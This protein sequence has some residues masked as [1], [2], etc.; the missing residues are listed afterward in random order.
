MQQVIYAWNY[1][2]WGGAQIHILSL[3]KEVRKEFRIIVLLPRGSDPQFTNFLENQDVEYRFFDGH[4]D[5]SAANTI[6]KRIH[7]RWSKVKSEFAML[8]LIGEFDL[9]NSIVHVELVPHQSL[10]SIIWLALHGPVFITC[11]N[12]LP[13]ASKWREALWRLR[14]RIISRFDNF[15]VFCSNI[16][17]KAY[18]SEQYSSEFA[19]SIK[20][21]YTSIDPTE[22]EAAKILANDRDTVRK[23]Y[24]IL[25][26]EIVVLAVGN[27]ID[28]KGRWTLLDASSRVLKSQESIK[29]VWL[30]PKLPDSATRLKIEDRKL[31]DNFQLILSSEV[32]SERIDILRFFQMADI[33]ALPSFVE[34]LPIALL[35][36]MATGLPSI[37]TNVNAI[38]EAICH[39]VTGVLVEPGDP[40]GLA[41]SILLLANDRDLRANLG[42]QGRDF[43]IEHFDERNV[44]KLVSSEY[45]K[46]LFAK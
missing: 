20:V 44:A 4:L 24:G 19:K 22:I 6:R 1:L 2:E 10:S 27:F 5:L 42:E 9:S 11:H 7:R 46:A 21:T 40:E 31:G 35:E 33:F 28:R 18:F 16:D 14:C 8:K 25:D 41:E 32:G 26:D 34:G 45:N 23:R 29:F 39:L 37:S 43:C 30:T 38:P 15:H 36:A 13:T 3:I 12:R 17:A